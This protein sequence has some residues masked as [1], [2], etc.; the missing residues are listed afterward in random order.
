MMH[1]QVGDVSSMASKA[2]SKASDKPSIE[3]LNAQYENG[4]ID[5]TTYAILMLEHHNVEIEY[6]D[7]PL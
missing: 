3:S 4:Q 5:D 1:Q 2:I 7:S 6:E